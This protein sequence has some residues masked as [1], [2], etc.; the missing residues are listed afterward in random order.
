[1]GGGRDWAGR[2]GLANGRACAHRQVPPPGSSADFA[3]HAQ[4]VRGTFATNPLRSGNAT[5]R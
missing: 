2:T 1:M 3:N 4:T 5:T